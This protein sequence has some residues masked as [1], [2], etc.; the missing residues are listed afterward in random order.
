M[1]VGASRSTEGNREIALPYREKIPEENRS[2]KTHS[3]Q[4]NVFFF[5]G[6]E[7]GKGD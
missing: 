2:S 4:S 1:A 5:G 3:P 7:I 6:G